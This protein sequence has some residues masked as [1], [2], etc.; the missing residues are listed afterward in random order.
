MPAVAGCREGSSCSTPLPPVP[1][2]WKHWWRR[3]F[4]RTGRWSDTKEPTPPVPVRGQSTWIR[5]EYRP[6]WVLPARGKDSFPVLVPEPVFDR[7]C[8][9]LSARQATSAEGGPHLLPD[10]CSLEE[11]VPRG[12]RS[13]ASRWHKNSGS[14]TL[15]A[16]LGKDGHG[17]VAFD[18]LMDGPHLLVAGTTGA[19]KS[20]LLRT[21]SLSLAMNYPPYNW[22]SSSLTSKEDPACGRWNA[23][24]IAPGWSP[25]LAVR[26]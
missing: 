20:E 13:L 2:G 4:E 3:P 7:F 25:T 12:P 8:R 24:R 14:G 15:K 18:F 17:P 10:E 9:A 5:P 16:V 19:G 1:P 22:C 21:L 11:I 26:A 6:H 23:C